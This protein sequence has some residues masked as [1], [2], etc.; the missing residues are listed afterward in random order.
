MFGEYKA[1]KTKIVDNF[2]SQK[3][4]SLASKDSAFN[5]LEG[6]PEILEPHTGYMGPLF[7]SLSDVKISF[8]GSF[9][10]PKVPIQK[11]RNGKNMY[12]CPIALLV[13]SIQK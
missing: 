2:V 8:N 1:T 3:N 7:L 10:L 13:S 6:F 9:N 12:T 5:S 11:L 4:P